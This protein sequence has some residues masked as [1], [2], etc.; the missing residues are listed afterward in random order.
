MGL[1]WG[2]QLRKDIKQINKSVFMESLGF[3]L[4]TR[5]IFAIIAKRYAETL[6]FGPLAQLAEHLT[7][8]QGVRS[9]NLRWLISFMKA[10]KTKSFSSFLVFIY[11]YL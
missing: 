9:S 5:K 2:S 1:D 6:F 8:N 7:F 11:L 4:T 10:G 3:L